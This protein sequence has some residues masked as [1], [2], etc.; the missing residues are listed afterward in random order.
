MT[1]NK[2]L[3]TEIDV[4]C[5]KNSMSTSGL[6]RKFLGNP[7]FYSD[8]HSDKYSPLLKTVNKLHVRMK[9]HKPKENDDE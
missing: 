3:I 4:F 7:N 5:E 9:N 6:G 1:D 2:S 8:L